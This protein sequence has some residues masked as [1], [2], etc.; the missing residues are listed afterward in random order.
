MG[1]TEFS[2]VAGG[3]NCWSGRTQPDT[4]RTQTRWSPARRSVWQPAKPGLQG[5]ATASCRSSDVEARV[6]VV[7]ATRTRTTRSVSLRKCRSPPRHIAAQTAER[8][9]VETYGPSLTPSPLHELA[10]NQLPRTIVRSR[11]RH[12]RIPLQA[13]NRRHRRVSWRLCAVHYVHGTLPTSPAHPR[14]FLRSR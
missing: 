5:T 7:G 1:S 11:Q 3:Q 2:Q 12:H 10:V 14:V 8:P 9:T 6:R 13:P 4:I